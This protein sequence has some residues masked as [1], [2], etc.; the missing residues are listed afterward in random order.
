MNQIRITITN[1]CFGDGAHIR[2]TFFD[3]PV[4]IE[5]LSRGDNSNVVEQFQCLVSVLGNVSKDNGLSELWS[6]SEPVLQYHLNN[7]RKCSDLN[8]K[9]AEFL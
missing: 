8:N 6:R 1:R 5:E 2:P 7:W 3:N 4:E 9:L